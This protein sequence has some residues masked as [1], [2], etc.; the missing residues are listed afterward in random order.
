MHQVASELVGNKRAEF[1]N[2]IGP[3]RYRSAR[4]QL[5]PK[6]SLDRQCEQKRCQQV[7]EAGQQERD[8][9]WCG[10]NEETKKL[11]QAGAVRL[12]LF[13]CKRVASFE[14]ARHDH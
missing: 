10:R 4:P 2:E 1:S 7:E 14:V 3:L 12:S 8:E 11:L 5:G 6:A 13:R 9:Q